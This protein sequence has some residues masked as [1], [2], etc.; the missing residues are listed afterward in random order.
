MIYL[1]KL[2]YITLSKAK[3]RVEIYIRLDQRVENMRVGIAID[4]SAS[5]MS[6]FAANIPKL[7]RQ[8]G[9]NVMEPVVRHLSRYICDYSGDGTVSLLYWAVD[10]FNSTQ[11]SQIPV[12]GPNQQVWGTG[13]KLL[14]ALNYFISQFKE[15]D[16]TILLFI[17][18]GV[19]EDFEEV[20]KRAMEVIFM[21][22]IDFCITLPGTARILDSKHQP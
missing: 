4:G 21:A 18:D 15:A 1:E 8:P 9:A 10:T 16:W 2:T 5:M 11:S 22:L 17:S 13:T 14:P 3:K 7:F 12:D 6:L 20:K 19:L